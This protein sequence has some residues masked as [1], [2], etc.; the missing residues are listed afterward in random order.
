MPAPAL[1]REPVTRIFF[2]LT[3]GACGMAA[4]LALLPAAGHD[5]MWLLYAARLVLHGQTL[6]GPEVFENNPPL[7]VWLSAV[8]ESLSLL[9]DIPDTAL[10]KLFV[11]LLECG[12][13]ALCLRL[14][15]LIRPVLGPATL[16]GLAFAF[17]T[18]F[19]VLPAR[20][21][22][23][24]D[25]LLI[26]LL[27]PYVFA[28]AVRAEAV[29]LPAG[30]GCFAGTLAL[31]GCALKPH[32][33]VVILFVEA[34]ILIS[35]RSP[36]SQLLRPE[37]LAMLLS[38]TLF[39]LAV[40]RV[41]PLYFSSVVPLMRD[42]YWAYGS[43]TLP[44]LLGESIQLHLLLLADVILL[45]AGGWR[46]KPVIARMLLVAGLAS[47][48]AFYMQGT[49]WYY[50]QI[51]ALSFLSFALAFLL[52]DRA[53]RK[54]VRLPSWTTSAAAALAIL[55]LALTTHF[56]N[57]PFTAER[58]FPIDRP[59]P[60]FFAGLPPGT[61]VMTLSPSVDDTIMPIF[62]YHLTLGQ[63]YSSFV[64]LPALLRSEDP[65][66]EHLRHVIPPARLAELDRIQ[67]AFMVE[68]L[69]RW[70][71]RLILVERCQDPSVHC[72]VLEDRH[73]DLLAFFERDPAF[74]A[75]FAQYRF[76]RGSGAY[77]EYSRD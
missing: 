38:G 10:G 25:H 5:Q 14:L 48:L 24:R 43:L 56:M 52:I 39:L 34:A 60:G 13:A 65:R 74:A 2:I 77:E 73:D 40:F 11:I 75:I 76:V 72:Q 70:R 46:S 6:Y 16:A 31:M 32:Q 41:A 21:F 51:P 67:H 42:T 53:E 64:M 19:A 45:F 4:L 49:G 71:P 1:L 33:L 17:V 59:D 30:L 50:Q 22:G 7:I 29:P 61:A 27:F 62:K 57:Y 20:D 9:T 37:L 69:N 8:P 23:Q 63:R 47:T 35:R 55:A 36:L 15:R 3:P 26:L 12:V 68:D 58:S 44:E 28:A 66:G 54:P 18:I